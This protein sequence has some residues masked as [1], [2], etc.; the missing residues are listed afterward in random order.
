MN[1]TGAGEGYAAL[2][3]LCADPDERVESLRELQP[4]E[5]TVDRQRAVFAALANEA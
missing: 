3:R 5:G 2:C 4:P 1:S